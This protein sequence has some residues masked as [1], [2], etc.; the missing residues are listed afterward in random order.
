M[1][2]ARLEEIPMILRRSVYFTAIIALA[3]VR[4]VLPANEDP[5]TR[6]SPAPSAPRAIER[7]AAVALRETG[8][9]GTVAEPQAVPPRAELGSAGIRPEES[10][11][12]R[13]PDAFFEEVSPEASERVS[14]WAD[15]RRV[16]RERLVRVDLRQLWPR[17]VD[18]GSAYPPMPE[19]LTFDLF[20]DAAFEIILDRLDSHSAN[21]SGLIWLGHVEGVEDSSVTLAIHGRA[22][23]ALVQLPSGE[24]F[25]L[26][27]AGHGVH[28]ILELDPAAF[29]PEE[30]PEAVEG[31]TGL[32][33]PE[34]IEP[35][36]AADGSA[37]VD[38]MVLYT[39]AARD[40]A[41][42]HDAIEA[43]IQL[44]ISVA[45]QAYENSLVPIRHR[46]VHSELVN[47]AETTTD[48]FNQA[49]NQIT[50]GG[51]GVMDGIHAL[52]D[53]HGADVVSLLI[54]DLDYCGLAWVVDPSQEQASNWAFNVNLWYCVG[55]TRTLHHEIGHNQG[56]QHD[57]DN[58]GSPG[59]FPY[60]Y[61]LQVDGQFHT[62]MAYDS[63]SGCSAPCP[64]INYFSN[65]LVQY[66]G[67]P[68]GGFSQTENA[69]SLTE[70]RAF[71]SNWRTASVCSD[72]MD[73]DGDGRVDFPEDRDCTGAED[74]SEQPSCSDG[75]DNDGDG[76]M[77]FPD[78][79]DCEGPEDGSEAA[80]TDADADGVPNE[81]DNCL[82]LPNPAQRDSDGDGYGNP[83]DC[84]FDND[85]TCD[86]TDYLA[87]AEGFGTTAPAGGPDIDQNGNGAIDGGDFLLFGD[88]YG[89]SPGPS[90]LTCAGTIPCPAP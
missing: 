12:S 76:R 4:F 8:L 54:D 36:A 1:P 22:V 21:G 43:R 71:V 47:Y 28:R 60:S 39:P 19:R 72:G 73:N 3:V 74:P 55:T 69:R 44:A 42:G 5:I 48:A 82:E 20:E 75:L 84:D 77:D 89:G 32:A 80:G 2:R 40:A 46:L 61:G 15:E 58:A 27:H 49:L 57:I 34:P 52:R 63:R 83:C 16:L 87:L 53:A 38:V 78:D 29:P 9:G 11:E 35:A 67:T 59:V 24:R 13:V 18:P 10:P 79:L 70:T 65:P 14:S 6:V 25:E 66:Q 81:A 23:Q 33:E 88:G 41:G 90:G 64:S 51:D 68:T 45:N 62:V 26:T 50:D 85:N 37:I 7:T 31:A 56:L 86:G 17:S 30:E